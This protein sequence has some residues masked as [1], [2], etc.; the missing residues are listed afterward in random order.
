[1]RKCSAL[2]C[3][4]APTRLPTELL[5]SVLPSVI[6]VIF[7]LSFCF[8][9]LLR[10]DRVDLWQSCGPSAVEPPPILVLPRAHDTQSRRSARTSLH[11]SGVLQRTHYRGRTSA[12]A[13]VDCCLWNDNSHGTLRVGLGKQRKE[14]QVSPRS[15]KGYGYSDIVRAY[16]KVNRTRV[17]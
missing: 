10:F 11:S 8:T 17:S 6:L 15:T 12:S 5:S 14:P 9:F 3:R 7:T 2:V 16:V 1:M 13:Q 4:D